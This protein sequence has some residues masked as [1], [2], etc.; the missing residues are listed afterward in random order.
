MI[1]RLE[2]N[3][4][5]A[6]EWFEINN[7]K[8]SQN[9]YHLIV[10]GRKYENASVKIRNERIWESAKQKL[11]RKEIGRDLNFDDHVLSLCKK[12]GRKLAVLAR[13]WK[14]MSFRQ[15]RILME[16]FVEF[17]F[18]Y[19]PLV[20]IFHSRKVNSKINHL[21][22]RTIFSI[23]ITQPSLKIYC[24]RKALSKFTIKTFN[25]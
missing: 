3:A 9:K 4:F 12:A 13:L 18:R 1:K 20:W 17:R 2:H 19:C 8:L 21:R 22:S 16:T 15:K 10:S 6:N 11:L 23:M 24:R 5:L 25:R 7:M 14:L